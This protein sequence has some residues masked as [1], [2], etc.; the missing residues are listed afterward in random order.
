M[1]FA[2]FAI[3]RPDSLELRLATRA[4]HLD[5]LSQFDTPVAGPLLDDDGNMCGSMVFYDAPSKS[6]VEQIVDAD[7]YNRA[8]LF[9]SITIREFKT[10]A[11]PA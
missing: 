5:Y 10:V 3:D 9:E 1:R 11:W 8:G 7:P 4:A 2:V 6:A